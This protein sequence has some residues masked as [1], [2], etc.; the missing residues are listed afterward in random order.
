[1]DARDEII[2][3]QNIK[4][5]WLEKKVE[6]LTALVNSLNEKLNQNSRNSHRPPSSDGPGARAGKQKSE[7][8]KRARGGQ[9]GHRG[10]KRELIPVEEVSRFVEVFPPQ[11][12]NCWKVLPKTFDG[13]AI[14]FQV[15]E[16]PVIKIHT[17][18]YRCH[19]VKCNCGYT[20]KASNNE[21]PESQFGP[22]LTSLV[23]LLTG[24]Y[25]LSRRKTVTL[26]QDV[27]SIN[28]SL[29]G[30]SNIEARVSAALLPASNEAWN[31][32]EES[33]VKHT[34]ATS[35]LQEGKLRSLWT[36]ATNV[37]TVFRILL[38]GSAA[39]VAPLFRKCEGVLV[40][41]RATVFSFWAMARRQICWAHLLR[42]FIS[43]SEK[44]GPA[45]KL[46]DELLE[47]TSLIFEYWHLLQKKQI[48]RQRFIELMVPV[49]LQFAACLR[50]ALSANIKEV[51]GSCADILVHEKALWLFVECEN[52]E[53]TNNHAERELRGFVLWR[54]RSFGTQSLRGNIFAERI[55]TVAHTARKQKKNVFEFLIQSCN[56]HM[57]GTARPSLF[58]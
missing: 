47:F 49:R 14:R 38:N 15:T 35:W 22:R 43:F 28:I 58:S 17:T 9:K 45:K 54:K 56:A 48:E 31:K 42:K 37:A 18:E 53:P 39:H 40:S 29:G 7:D 16:L 20:T 6:E 2:A 30:V 52:V 11:C 44:E 24:I 5:A 10:F 23:G 34:D 46:G 21:I 13:D 19:A 55:M 1:M 33:A 27:L 51:S 26:L 57:T 8:E 12:E 3:A 41:D 4:I 50:R 36:I 32:V 25:H